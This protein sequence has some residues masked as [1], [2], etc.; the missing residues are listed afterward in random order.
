[1]ATSLGV[2]LANQSQVVESDRSSHGQQSMLAKQENVFLQ[3]IESSVRGCTGAMVERHSSGLTVS[4]SG[5]R[6]F[7]MSVMVENGR[8]AVYFDNWFEEFDCPDAARQMFEAALK[9]EARLKVDMLSG[10]RW[11]W[12]LERRDEAGTWQTESTTGH[13]IW[14]FW[15]RQSS[16]YLRNAFPPLML[17]T[18][19]AGRVRAN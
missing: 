15:G 7:R 18:D 3:E 9:G 13:V 8:Y 16:V 5:P 4:A 6:G 17:P 10:R 14:R 1:M 12:T 19:A 11:R 2:E